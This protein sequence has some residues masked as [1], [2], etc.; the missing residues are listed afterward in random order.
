MMQE[1]KIMK[2]KQYKL[3][4]DDKVKGLRDELLES[5]RQTE[6]HVQTIKTALE[7]YRRGLFREKD[8][9]STTYGQTKGPAVMG[10]IRQRQ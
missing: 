3:R 1:L 5:P 8:E 4:L 7:Q 6:L 10:R 9:N 2:S